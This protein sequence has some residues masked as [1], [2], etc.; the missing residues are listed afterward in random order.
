[1]D[2]KIIYTE[3]AREDLMKIALDL[4]E[5]T[6]SRECAAKYIS[7]IQ[8]ACDNLKAFPAC[9]TVPRDRVLMS[10]G[11]RFVQYGD[12]LAFYLHDEKERLVTVMA[13]FNGKLDYP[14]Y[15]KKYIR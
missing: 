6:G 5:L 9:G 2:Y 1:M 12:Y 14:S 11:Y 13:V 4:F 10:M 7:G 15:M 8:T 3:T